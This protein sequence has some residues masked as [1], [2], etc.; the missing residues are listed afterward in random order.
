MSC[1]P[2][3]GVPNASE[4]GSKSTHSCATSD[5]IPRPKALGPPLPATGVANLSSC[6]PLLILSPHAEALGT[7]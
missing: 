5:F 7:P 4:R 1:L 6:G 3:G 2:F